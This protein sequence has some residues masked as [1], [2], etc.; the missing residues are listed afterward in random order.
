MPDSLRR[1]W[2][3]V[4]I[5]QSSYPASPGRGPR[6][7]LAMHVTV[8]LFA[9][10]RERAGWSQREFDLPAGASLGD[11]WPVLD[12]GDEPPGVAYARNREYAERS[13]RLADGDEI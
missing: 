6:Y 5:G 8:K 1:G 3:A 13:E 7:D 11:V 9:A 10:L 12:L 2:S 4:A